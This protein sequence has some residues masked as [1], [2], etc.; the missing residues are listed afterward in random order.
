VTRMLPKDAVQLERAARRQRVLLGGKLVYGLAEYSVD[1]AIRDLSDVGARVKLPV[2]LPT[3]N[4]VWLIDINRAMAYRAEVAWRKGAEM[5]LT[6]SE[7]H[8][9]RAQTGPGMLHLRT[10]WLECATRRPTA[11]PQDLD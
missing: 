6:F 7:G 3:D 9:L 1:C 8:D 11:R 2:E 10:L 4:A 5:G